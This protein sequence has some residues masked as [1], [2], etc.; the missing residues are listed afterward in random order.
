MTKQQQKT[1]DAAI[2]FKYEVREHTA[3]SERTEF[4]Y[5]FYNALSDESILRSPLTFKGAQS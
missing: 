4:W 2:A 1:R 5:S 3:A